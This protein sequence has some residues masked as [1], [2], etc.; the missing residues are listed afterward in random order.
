MTTTIVG[1]GSGKGGG[2]SSRTPRTARD[3]LD[4]REFA[5]V[6]EVIAEGPIEGLANG[7]QS[8]FLN[9]TPL[10]NANGTYNFQDVDLYERTGTAN[11]TVIPLDSSLAVLSSTVVNVPVTKDYPVTRTIT[12]T[13]VDAVRVTITIPSLQK[14]NSS[15]G[16]TLGTSVQLKIAVKYTNISTGNETAYDEV[17]GYGDTDEDKEIIKGRTADPY[18]REYEIR[19]KKGAGEIGENSTYTIKVTR[20]TEDSTD[21]LHSNAFNWSSFT[22]VKFAPQTYDNTALIGIRLDAQQFSSIPSR[23]YDIKGLKVQIPTGVTVDSDTGRIIY[24]TNYLWDGTFQAATW[25]SCPSWLLYALLLNSRFGLGDHFD[26]SQLDKWAFFRASKYAN[27]EVSYTLDGATTKEARFSC[28]ATIN[29]TDEAYNVINQLLSVMRCQG[30]WEDGSLTI[31]QDS[32]SDPVYNFNQSNVT[33]E[34]FSYTNASNKNKPTVVVVAYLDLV[35]KDRAYEVVKDTAAIAK[36]GV[37]KRSVTAFACTSRAQANRL[38]KWLLYE[39]NNSEVVAFTSNLVTAQLL[40]T[41]Q[42]ISISDPVKAGS[43]RA[44]RISSA[45]INSINIDDGGTVSNIDLENSPSLSVVLADGTFDSGHTIT[46]IDL[47]YCDPEY[48]VSGY[49]GD[50]GKITIASNFQAIPQANSVWV[51]E[52][53]QLQ[54]SLWRVI[55]IK[56]ENDFLYTVEA[57]SHNESKF[58]HIEQN[59]SLTHRDT[60]NLNVIP[61]TPQNVEILDIPRH[62]GTT[63]KEL[64]YELNGKIALKITFHWAGVLGVDRYKVKWRHEDDNF[65]TQIVNNTTI[66]LMDVKVGTYE[67][68]VSSM[69]SSGLLFSEPSFGEYDVKGL[70]ANPDDITGLSMVPISETL[71]VLSWKEVTQLNVKLGGRIIIR[72]DPRTSGASWLTSNKIVDGVSGASTQK[73][74]PLLAGTYFVKAQDYLGNNSTN[75]ASFI[76]TLPETT[77]RLNVKT[78]SEETAF[79]GDKNNSGLAVTGNNLVLTPDP[80][81]VSG[82]HDPFYVNGDEEGEY[83]FATT[84]DF[85]HAGVQYDAVLRKEVISNSIAATGTA[86]DARSGLF[87]AA[88]G[89]IDGDVLDEANVDLYVR[90]TPDDPSSSPTWGNWAEFEAAII[91]ARGIEVKAVITSNNTD[92]KVTISDLGATLD[93]LQR[94]DSASIAANTSAST[95]V[96]NVTFEK[97]FYDTPEVQI[98]PN[99]SSSNLFVSVSSLSRTGFTATFNNGSNVDTAFMYTVTGFGRAI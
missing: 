77:R 70:R 21:S 81:V 11:Q 94:T 57:V 50:S 82:Y 51:V 4:S 8:V 71:A 47:T 35:L 6:T 41:G 66:D 23:K 69:S 17:I 30:F 37:V 2:G 74:V 98:T 24:P 53:S 44:G 65:T 31:A 96:Y 89:T 15:N 87:D 27:E 12:D 10:Q 3:S 29:S 38:G 80:Y 55:G 34:G 45:T 52:S 42:I 76:T 25:T 97:A 16:D 54:T 99:A 5:N 75:P 78:W 32:P 67:I 61:A 19:F 79:S 84:F 56:E 88:S 85:G 64:Q 43:R 86:W 40:K 22:T 58:A 68:Q 92:A 73:Q 91:R 28:N 18:N 95:G 62:D 59:L 49:T 90:T 14:I 33:E 20:V 46:S 7:L 1:A 60:T 26:S 13:S 72:H 63:T 83:T 36:R 39:E 93:L 48:W 9:D